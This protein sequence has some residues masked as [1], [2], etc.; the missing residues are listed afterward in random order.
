MKNACVKRDLLM[1]G[2]YQ[3]D[4]NDCGLACIFTVCKMAGIPVN[5]TELRKKTFLGQDGLSLYGMTKIME[6]VGFSADAVSGTIE[7]L[8]EEYKNIKS[9]IIVL[10]NENHMG[11]YVVMYGL[12]RIKKKEDS[13]LGSKYWGLSNDN[14]RVWEVMVW[15]CDLYQ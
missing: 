13:T 11:H 8:M 10:I 12:Y 3:H 1:R 6:Q 9:P 7:E 15:I 5:E 4:E 14:G 2:Y